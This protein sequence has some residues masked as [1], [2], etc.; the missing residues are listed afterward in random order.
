MLPKRKNHPPYVEVSIPF[1]L[2][3][4]SHA[5]ISM[6]LLLGMENRWK[7]K[8]DRQLLSGYI[9]LEMHLLE[10]KKKKGGISPR[11]ETLG[12]PQISKWYGSGQR[13]HIPICHPWKA[14]TFVAVSV[15]HPAAS[16]RNQLNQQK[17]SLNYKGF[18]RGFTGCSKVMTKRGKKGAL[19]L[20]TLYFICK[21]D[22]AYFYL[23]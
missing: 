4:T 18:G 10:K 22:L 23:I 16:S 14:E 2:A 15:T 9:C 5:D 19:L 17:D 1:V 7:I 11:V 12:W 6:H 8:A 20:A 13:K 3:S 21:R